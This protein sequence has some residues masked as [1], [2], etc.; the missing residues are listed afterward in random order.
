MAA[1]SPTLD[2]VGKFDAAYAAFLAMVADVRPRLHRYCSRMTGSVMDGE[3]V[4]QEVLFD[5]YRGLDSLEHGRA[6]APWLFRIAHNRCID[7]LRERQARQ[8]RESAEIL[9]SDA[10][11]APVE[12]VGAD[13]DRAL[14]R[15]VIN[16]PP[17]ERA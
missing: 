12:P 15:L 3:D 6:L 11:T 2:E 8:A 10:F 7:L 13:V 17:K 14:E 9:A 5:A 1:T 4:V 16:L